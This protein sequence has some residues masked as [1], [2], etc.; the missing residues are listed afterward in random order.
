MKLILHVYVI[1]IKKLRSS[2]IMHWGWDRDRGD[3]P[4]EE[5]FDLKNKDVK[6]EK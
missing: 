5:I 4:R 3:V 1:V 2:C 6:E